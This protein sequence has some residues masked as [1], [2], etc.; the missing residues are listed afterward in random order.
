[1]LLHGF[2]SAV[3]GRY[4]LVV[5][6]YERVHGLVSVKGLVREGYVEAGQ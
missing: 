5:E 1:M 3:D 6:F 2:V 4:G